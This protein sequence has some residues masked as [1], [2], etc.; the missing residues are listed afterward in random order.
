VR[1]LPLILARRRS[2]QATRRVS[3]RAFADG[4]TT[5]LDSPHLAM[6][7]ALPGAVPFQAWFFAH[8]RRLL[9]A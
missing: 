2:I 7:H 4:L 5:S 9:P 1:E 6:A 8:L 3:A